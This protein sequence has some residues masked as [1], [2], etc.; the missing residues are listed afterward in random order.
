MATAKCMNATRTVLDAGCGADETTAHV[1]GLLDAS[2]AVT[3]KIEVAVPDGVPQHV[4]RI[5]TEIGWT[6]RFISHGFERDGRLTARVQV[7]GQ[8]RIMYSR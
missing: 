5:V 4:V 1:S 7:M 6:L 3:L 8:C 2:V